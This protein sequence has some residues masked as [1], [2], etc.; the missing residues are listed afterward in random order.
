[1]IVSLS[2][3]CRRV[4]ITLQSARKFKVFDVNL[5]YHSQSIYLLFYLFSIHHQVIAMKLFAL[6]SSSKVSFD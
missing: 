5:R 2:V 4:L 6:C 3:N 1:M